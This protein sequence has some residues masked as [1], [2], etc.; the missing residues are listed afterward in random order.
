VESA[1]PRPSP[2]PPAAD[3]AP[4]TEHV[5]WKRV[6]VCAGIVA[7]ALAV[8]AALIANKPEAP[9]SDP[10][11]RRPGVRV[12]EART[13]VL[14]PVVEGF[15]R[16]R[17]ARR[18]A[19]SAEVAGRV[20]QVA[21]ALEDGRSLEAGALALE[22]EPVDFQARVDAAAAQ[23]DGARA[24]VEQLEQQQA[25]LRERVAVQRQLLAL[26][27]AEL[28]R[29]EGLEG[30]GV[31]GEREL[32]AARRA[33]LR[34]QDA[35]ADLAG[36]L[37]SSSPQLVAT[38]ARVREVEAAL[39]TARAD[40]ARTRIEAPFAGMVARVA[41]EAHQRVNPGQTLFELWDVAR[42]EVPVALSLEQAALL[43]PDLC[44]VD[45]PEEGRGVEVTLQAGGIRR[46][47]RGV[48]RR[49]EPVD[50]ETQTVKAV[51]EVEN[52]A[53]SGRGAGPGSPSP[54]LPDVFCAVAVEAPPTPA[55]LTIPREAVQER[56]RAYVVREGRLAIVPVQLGRAVGRWVLVEVGLA[57]GDLVIVSPLDRAVE[58]TPVEALPDGEA[59]AK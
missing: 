53:P 20:R 54:L 21:E 26:E 43:A 18:V 2:L 57:E 10:P 52:P 34:S 50:G 4:V 42:V 27:R 5:L 22:I 47:W 19:I 7:G 12:V 45:G 13:R 3:A 25:T 6:A 38:R 23:L 51:V 36:R 11:Q 35:L 58:G 40:L 15:G 46:R 44:G 41:V 17:P 32:D 16:V 1:D 49:F 37:A 39:T 48:L 29:T 56:S 33:L 24:S 31:A 8:A 14:T 9:R 28:R 55:A 59:E 30:K